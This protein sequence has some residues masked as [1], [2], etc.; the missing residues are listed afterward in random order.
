MKRKS[1]LSPQVHKQ[2]I[3]VVCI[4]V[5]FHLMYCFLPH[6]QAHMQVTSHVSHNAELGIMQRR[7]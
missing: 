6:L 3:R 2:S 1:Y 7:L 4:P 5:S